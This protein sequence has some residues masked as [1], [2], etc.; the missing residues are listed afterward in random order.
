MAKQ[1]F[2]RT[3]PHVNIG[4][5][6]HVDHGK[7]TLTAAL[8]GEGLAYITDETVCIDP[9]SLK[10]EPFSKPLT[11]KPGSQ[12]LLRH[13]EPPALQRG[14]AQERESIGRHLH[15][16]VEFH[17]RRAA[18]GRG[19]RFEIEVGI[20]GPAGVYRARG[21]HDLAHARRQHRPT[22]HGQ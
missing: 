1:K 8:V 5:I 21:I 11:V 7:T 13:L 2:E 15:R 4:T 12:E 14:N 22:Q 17:A 9:V 16:G 3:K 6:G 19:R 20:E 10:I 18:V